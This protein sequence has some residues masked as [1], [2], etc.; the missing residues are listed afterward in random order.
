MTRH[1]VS[2]S[3]ENILIRRAKSVYVPNTS[4]K[5]EKNTAITAKAI[6][7]GISLYELGYCLE[8]NALIELSS[9][10]DETL[11]NILEAAKELVGANWSYEPMYPNFPAQVA[12]ASLSELY[13]NAMVHYFGSQ[14]SDTLSIITG[15][16]LSVRFVPN[17]DKE[18]RLDFREKV[19]YRKLAVIT[20][21]HEDFVLNIARSGQALSEQDRLDL[22]TIKEELPEL[23]VEGRKVAIPIKENL[24]WLTVNVPEFDYSES[25]A[26]A[27]DVL[28]LAIAYSD[29][30]ITLA[31]PT[32]FNIGRP[33]RRKLMYLTER[34]LDKH[35]SAALLEDMA[36]H[37]EEWKRLL[38]RLHFHEYDSK[39]SCVDVFNRFM[40]GEGVS[41]NSN[42]E[43]AIRNKNIGK[44]VSTLSKRPGVYARRLAEL[45][46]KFPS[47][48]DRERILEG[49]DAV[50]EQVSLPVLIQM[51]NLFSGPT[52]DELENR[53]VVVKSASQ[54]SIVIPNRN[55]SYDVEII[56]FIE[57]A[58]SK[59]RIADHVVLDDQADQYVVPLNVRA[60]SGGS[61]IIGR[62]SRIAVEHPKKTIRA[63]MHWHDMDNGGRVDLDLSALLIS[64][65]FTRSTDIAYYNL[66]EFGA[67]HSGD[68]TSAPNGA[69]EFIDINVADALNHGFRYVT[70]TIYNYTNQPLSQVP[71]ASAGIMFRDE[72]NDG[73]IFEAASVDTKFD[74]TSD[75]VNSTPFVFDLKT[76]EIIWWDSATP[77]RSGLRN[78]STNGEA[79][80]T[81][82][83]S[84]VV[85]RPMT[86]KKLFS[87]ISNDRSDHE[88]KIQSWET[89]KVL[90]YLAS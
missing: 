57:K 86:L 40:S 46:R 68:L 17:T 23:F 62:G 80:Y 87:L 32:R 77:I 65:D 4:S 81:T 60:A 8:P 42:V 67:Y 30:D 29:G 22:L 47:V 14:I 28:R 51:W 69:A 72:P 15:S 16:Q 52:T 45:V 20:A 26:T 48:K 33:V 2:Q 55:T 5:N 41:Y 13:M 6:T 7:L 27:T 9:A 83:K 43:W 35:G 53:T 76:N 66:K 64:E 63:F 36:S 88:V 90:P 74:L 82:V 59:H 85:S 56:A 21:I 70:P 49:F 73:E 37:R 25:Y 61:R 34:L 78:L 84:L 1:T 19:T 50:S 12:N 79:A 11:V 24:V 75:S 3:L 89:D 44:I 54:K 71:E 38:E 18:A 58:I 31:T 10:S 39:L